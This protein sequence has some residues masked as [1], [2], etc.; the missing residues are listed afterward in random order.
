MSDTKIMYK[1]AFC[2]RL[3]RLGISPSDLNAAMEKQ[4]AGP[5]VA[6]AISKGTAA[7]G[8]FAEGGMKAL[9]TILALTAGVPLLAGYGA[10]YLGGKAEQFGD[11][12]IEAVKREQSLINYEN[13]ISQ[14]KNIQQEAPVNE[15]PGEGAQF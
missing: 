13:A 5:G 11:S 12:D 14:L 2:E 1:L 4:A 15:H 7:V 6:G 10:G 9:Y 8:G 3:A